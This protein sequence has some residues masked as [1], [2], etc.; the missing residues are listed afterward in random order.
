MSRGV[1]KVEVIVDRVPYDARNERLIEWIEG[2]LRARYVVNAY[3]RHNNS[4][5]AFVLARDMFRL[6]EEMYRVVE[7]MREILNVSTPVAICS[8][9]ECID[10]SENKEETFLVIMSNYKIRKLEKIKNM[11]KRVLAGVDLYDIYVASNG[12]RVWI[13]TRCGRT[14]LYVDEAITISEIL[15]SYIRART[16]LRILGEVADTI[17]K[18]F[19]RT[20]VDL[21]MVNIKDIGDGFVITVGRCNMNLDYDEALQLVYE[22]LT[23]SII[24][25]KKSIIVAGG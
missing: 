4:E 18:M 12:G 7:V 25:L 13:D 22:L 16:K 8:D 21:S 9:S 10:L 3:S 24:G 17:F 1:K 2:W 19:N 14:T 20:D 23:W 11:V 5:V 6:F 15:L